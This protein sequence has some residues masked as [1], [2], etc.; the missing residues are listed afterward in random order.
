MDTLVT[1]LSVLFRVES[2]KESSN[3]R[4]NIDHES[5]GLG[6]NVD[7]VAALVK[8]NVEWM[9]WHEELLDRPAQP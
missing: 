7:N 3:I 8:H 9:E 2:N 4:G 1:V 5:A 6:K